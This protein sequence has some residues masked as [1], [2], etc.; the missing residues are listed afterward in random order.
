MEGGVGVEDRSTTHT[1]VYSTDSTDYC[2]QVKTGLINYY[3][4][5][6]QD[7]LLDNENAGAGG[8][9]ARLWFSLLA[10]CKRR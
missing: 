3:G 10:G 8:K 9:K 7:G 6:P 4:L 1:G 5:K 2:C